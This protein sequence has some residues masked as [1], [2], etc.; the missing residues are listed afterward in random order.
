MSQEKKVYPSQINTKSLACRVPAADY[1]KF[2]QEA[3]NNGVNLNDWL[4]LKI[5]GPKPEKQAINGENSAFPMKVEVEVDNEHYDRITKT[6]YF[7]NSDSLISYIEHQHDSL[8]H[9][10]NIR[11]SEWASIIE[12]LKEMDSSVK[13][14]EKSVINYLKDEVEWDSMKEFHAVKQE[15]SNQFKRLLKSRY[16]E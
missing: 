1:V 12:E 16:N 13:E 8:N 7:E 5:Y 4:L 14:I 2:L 9:L 15:I 6:L 11:K 3:I 10:T